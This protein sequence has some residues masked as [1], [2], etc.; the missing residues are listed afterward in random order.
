MDE[1][2]HRRII[3]TPR[4]TTRNLKFNDRHDKLFSLALEDIVILFR[5]LHTANGALLNQTRETDFNE[6]VT[7]VMLKAKRMHLNSFLY[8]FR[9][10]AECVIC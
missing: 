4:K 2:R 1:Q 8:N 5:I 3:I 6:F 9:N 10:I 7:G